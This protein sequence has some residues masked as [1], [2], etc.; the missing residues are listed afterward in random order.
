MRTSRKLRMNYSIIKEEFEHIKGQI[1]KIRNSVKNKQ[2]QLAWQ[3]VNEVSERKST[4][5]AKLKVVGQEERLLKLKE[6][7]KNLFGN[8]PEITD[9][10]TEEIIHSK[11]NFK[12]GHFIED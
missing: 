9:K 6:H 11:L 10:L 8:P 7:F 2:F 12:F 4:L 3:K 1:N 5:R